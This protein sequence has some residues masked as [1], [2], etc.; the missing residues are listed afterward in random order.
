MIAYEQKL[1]DNLRWGFMEGSMHFEKESA[2]HETLRKITKRLDQ[3][4]IPYAVVGGMACSF[5]AIVASR[6]MWTFW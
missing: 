2:V 4:G 3:L 6:T 5:T 1:R